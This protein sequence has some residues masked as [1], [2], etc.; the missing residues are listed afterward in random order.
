MCDLINTLAN[1]QF[2]DC[3]IKYLLGKS[4]VFSDDN[5]KF[6][7]E[8]PDSWRFDGIGGDMDDFGE[9]T[10]SEQFENARNEFWYERLNNAG[11]PTEEYCDFECPFGFVGDQHEFVCQKTDRE[12]L[13]EIVDVKVRRIRG[14]WYWVCKYSEDLIHDRELDIV[15][16]HL[17]YSGQKPH[18]AAGINIKEFKPF[19]VGDDCASIGYWMGDGD[20]IE[21]QIV[22]TLSDIDHFYSPNDFFQ[23]VH[24]VASIVGEGWESPANIEIYHRKDTPDYLNSEG[25]SL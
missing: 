21:F 3:G 11:E 25:G 16:W 1:W 24:A 13:V 10:L 8:E 15:D 23:K 14:R 9:L 17:K 4:Y 18:S 5:L 19:K 2:T 22:G 20:D 12:M 7:N 6:V